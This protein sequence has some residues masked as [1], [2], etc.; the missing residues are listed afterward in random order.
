MKKSSP[1]PQEPLFLSQNKST[2]PENQLQTIFVYLKDHVATASMVTD[3]TGVPQKCITRYK[4]DL[5]KADML[6]EIEK[7][8]CQKTGFKA[9]YLTTD[10]TLAPKKPKQ[11]NLFDNPIP[12]IQSIK[13]IDRKVDLKA[14]EY[15]VQQCSANDS[16]FIIMP[17]KADACRSIAW[18]MIFKDSLDSC[19]SFIEKLKN[20]GSHDKQS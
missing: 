9:W 18:P 12:T 15:E 7:K 4:R 20:P 2:T 8:D 3:A 16:L 17:F 6:W 1:I 10:P 14:N 11:L 13:V 5:E 19:D